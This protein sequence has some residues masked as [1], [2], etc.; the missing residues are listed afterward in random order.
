MGGRGGGGGEGGW[1]WRRGRGAGERKILGPMMNEDINSQE[2][3]FG[4][5][6]Q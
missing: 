6:F 3:S 1:R 5:A 4:K 2:F